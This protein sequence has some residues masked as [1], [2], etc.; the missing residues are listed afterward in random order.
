LPAGVPHIGECIVVMHARKFRIGLLVDGID[1]VAAPE[2]PVRG[3]L[4]I[5]GHVVAML[6]ADA[7]VGSDVRAY[8]AAEAA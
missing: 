2:R 5:S 7:I 4:E 8:L 1:G 6:D 3:I